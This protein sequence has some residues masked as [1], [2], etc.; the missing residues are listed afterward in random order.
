[1]ALL[2]KLFRPI[3]LV[4]TGV[5][6]LV[7]GALDFTDRAATIEDLNRSGEIWKTA[8]AWLLT[9]PWWVPAL[10]FLVM[11][12]LAYTPELHRLIQ[13][14]K[15][16][17]PSLDADRTSLAVLAAHTEELRLQ[18][19]AQAR[20]ND[21]IQQALR[22]AFA[23]RSRVS[24]GVAQAPTLIPDLSIRELFFYIDPDCLGDQGRKATRIGAD[25]LDKLSTG[26]LVAWGREA[27][28]GASPLTEI[29]KGYW[30]KAH[31]TYWYFD[32]GF[33]EQVVKTPP[34]LTPSEIVLCY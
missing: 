1:M 32:E 11:T 30:A 9:T 21:P 25:L 34:R 14:S 23:Q 28:H 19:E 2:W 16:A 12:G 27:D 20:E 10:L 13:S 18:R 5:I 3:W 8:L 31:L 15:P 33:Q 17:S 6:A 4:V 7:L 24:G 26:Q 22:T 29:G